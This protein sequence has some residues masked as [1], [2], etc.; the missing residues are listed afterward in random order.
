MFHTSPYPSPPEENLPKERTEATIRFDVF[1]V[2]F[3]GPI[4]YQG[5][6]KTEWKGYVMLDACSWTRALHL[7]FL[8]T[9][10]TEDFLISLKRFILVR[11]RRTKIISDNGRTFIAAST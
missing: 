1:G 4:L 10:T 11:G 3:A 2:D 5:K 9:M 6:G 7:E 8:P